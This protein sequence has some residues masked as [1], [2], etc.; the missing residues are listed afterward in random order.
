MSSDTPET[1][2]EQNIEKQRGN[3]SVEVV[4]LQEALDTAWDAYEVFGFTDPKNIGEKDWTVYRDGK[5]I[6][7]SERREDG[8]CIYT[9][10]NIHGAR[11]NW[12]P[13]E[14]GEG[15]DAVAARLP[16]IYGRE[17]RS[18]VYRWTKETGFS[19]V[20]AVADEGYP[21]A[22]QGAVVDFMED[23]WEVWRYFSKG[24]QR[25]AK[26]EDESVDDVKREVV[27]G[28]L[29]RKL[30]GVFGAG[31][32]GASLLSGCGPSG[33]EKAG[34]AQQPTVESAPEEQPSEV[35]EL[36]PTL[37]TPTLAEELDWAWEEAMKRMAKGSAE[38]S[39]AT[40]PV[41]DLKDE[42]LEWARNNPG[43]SAEDFFTH[44]K[45][46]GREVTEPVQD[47]IKEIWGAA[48]EGTKQ[49]FTLE[50]AEEMNQEGGPVDTLTPPEDSGGGW[51]IDK[52]NETTGLGDVDREVTGAGE[53]Q[54]PNANLFENTGDQN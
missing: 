10:T 4:T 12:L 36:I 1:K 15:F 46:G 19:K 28:R 44:L 6:G 23:E 29:S 41:R 37:G 40:E 54:D 30:A 9:P 34:A 11:L 32:V 53:E 16:D 31:V 8:V 39:D 38:F 22:L 26:R 48:Q 2:K 43:S 50:G 47:K 14:S 33:V 35:P 25:M 3:E 18:N 17:N 42:A 21:L 20:F 52:L 24:A 7:V 51:L 49:V 13:S 45:E 27:R 5:P